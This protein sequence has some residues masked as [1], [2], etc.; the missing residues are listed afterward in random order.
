MC[1]PVTDQKKENKSRKRINWVLCA[2]T[3]YGAQTKVKDCSLSPPKLKNHTSNSAT[4]VSCQIGQRGGWCLLTFQDGQKR[5][6]HCQVHVGVAL[7]HFQ[8]PQPPILVFFSLLSPHFSLNIFQFPNTVNSLRDR[9]KVMERRALHVWRSCRRR[10]PKSHASQCEQ[11][12]THKKRIM[13][14]DEGWAKA[15]KLGGRHSTPAQWWIIPCHTA[16]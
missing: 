15:W 3:L 9:E 13:H 5:R 4:R 2:A 8:V 14:A 16:G 7:K 10:K 1:R 12:R 11:P 6:Q